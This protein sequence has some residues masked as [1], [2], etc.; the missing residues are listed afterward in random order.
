MAIAS[1]R[2]LMRIAL[3]VFALLISLSAHADWKVVE[4]ANPEGPGKAVDVLNEGRAVARLIHG[5]GQIKPY[6][7]V[8][9]ES[10][11]L[12]TNSGADRDGK[13]TGTFP[14]HRGIFIGWKIISELDTDDLWHMTKGCRMELTKFQELKGA[15][16]SARIV[17][18]IT[19]RS[20]KSTNGSDLLIEE[21]RTLTFSRTRDERTQVDATFTLTPARD[22]RLAG[23]LQHSGVHFRAANEVHG[24]QSDTRYVCAPDG[25]AKGNNLKWCYLS[26]PIGTNWY[27]AVQFNHPSNPVEELSMR[28]YGR[29]GYFFKKD[30]KKGEPLTLKYRFLVE[31]T[32]PFPTTIS[33]LPDRVVA[34][35]MEKL[36]ADFA[37]TR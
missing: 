4:R 23:D 17:A 5:E 1:F 19:W 18:D 20:G 35:E 13:P 25:K 27:E 24:R 11:E 12:L 14:H 26:F 3:P 6:L 2:S 8:F 36:Y 10:G 34:D 9:G 29:F 7:H 16:D 22:L 31:H 30:M 21:R 37:K 32:A 28:K 33:P 15:K